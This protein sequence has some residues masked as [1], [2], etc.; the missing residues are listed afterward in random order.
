MTLVW[1]VVFNLLACKK[2]T[3]LLGRNDRRSLRSTFCEYWGICARL[4]CHVNLLNQ[5]QCRSVVT[6]YNKSVDPCHLHDSHSICMTSMNNLRFLIEIFNIS[7][8][9]KPHS[10][11][12][13]EP[14]APS[15]ANLVWKLSKNVPHG[16]AVMCLA[17]PCQ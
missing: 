13:I 11:Q 5:L 1:R 2:Q 6:C 16:I 7:S 9:S 3:R 10:Y 4:F 15:L 12:I 14:L 8:V 17:T